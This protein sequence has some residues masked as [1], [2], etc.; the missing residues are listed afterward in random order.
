MALQVRWPET[1]SEWALWGQTAQ[2]RAPYEVQEN[3]FFRGGFH[4]LWVAADESR[5][6]G[7]VTAW[8]R[9]FPADQKL[10]VLQDFEAESEGSALGLLR[11]AIAWGREHGATEWIGPMESF[12]SFDP[13]PVLRADDPRA[14]WL[15]SA[16]AEIAERWSVPR[17]ELR[18][19]EVG[20]T[21]Q[22]RAEKARTQSALKIAPLSSKGAAIGERGVRPE[23]LLALGVAPDRATGAAWKLSWRLGLLE[24]DALWTASGLSKWVRERVSRVRRAGPATRRSLVLQATWADEPA[25][26]ACLVEE[27][28]GSA[29]LDAL[30][31]APALRDFSIRE[32]LLAECVDTA[33]AWGAQDLWLPPVAQDRALAPSL[34]TELGAEIGE[35]RVVLLGQI[36][37]S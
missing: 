4:R 9:G 24:R 16:G 23:F 33:R 32:A 7:R 20:P 35:A 12:Q 2:E 25:G 8:H 13:L 11:A 34:W 27:R 1:S 31:T 14:E 3:P 21:V 5:V 6:S 19:R 10:L 28:D 15:S 36:P 17:F 18:M 26:F 30:K 29:R 22:G 37:A